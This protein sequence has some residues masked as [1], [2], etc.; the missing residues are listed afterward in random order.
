MPYNNVNISVLHVFIY[1]I[2]CWII[3]LYHMHLHLIRQE[4]S[5]D[6]PY[7]PCVTVPQE[8]QLTL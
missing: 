4:T 1:I 3:Y 5:H 2:N 8:V 7:N 6:V